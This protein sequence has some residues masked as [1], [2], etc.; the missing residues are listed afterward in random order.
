[1]AHYVFTSE[2]VTCGHPD[3]VCDQV[4]DAVLDAIL[5][6]DKLGRVAC[7]T[8]CTTG[9][10][11]VMG[12][13]TTTASVDIQKIARK[14]V[15]DIGYDSADAG[16]DGNTC[17][18]LTVLDEQ[19]ADIDMGVSKSLELKGGEEDDYNLHG[20]GDQGMMF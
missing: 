10:V 15:C 14:V 11:L 16:F 2:S 12:E 17:S 6:Q 3:K 7:E 9:M 5:A 8:C 20:A 13:I 4:S 18:V 19:S 1:M